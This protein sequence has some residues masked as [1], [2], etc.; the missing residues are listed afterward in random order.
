MIAGLINF[1]VNIIIRIIGATGYAGIFFLMLLESCGVPVPSEVIMPFSGFLV[2]SGQLIFALVVLAG[3]LGNLAGSCLAYCIGLKGGR[4]LIEKYGKYIF[5][6]KRDMDK[7]DYWFNRYGEPAVLLGRFLPVI[8]TYI[9]FPAGIAKMDLKKFC[10]FTTLGALPWTL[11][12]AWLGIKLQNHWTLIRDRLHNFDL[13]IAVL[14]VFAIALF[15][16]KHSGKRDK[17]V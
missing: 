10:F 12:F 4:P 3:T 16:W 15:F 6:S 7:A 8:R 9:S 17:I 1:I 14:I 5:I 2:A 13:A 11:L